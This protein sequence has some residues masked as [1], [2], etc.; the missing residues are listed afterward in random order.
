MN[1]IRGF[2]LLFLLAGVSLCEAQVESG[3]P[4]ISEFLPNPTGELETEWIELYNP[5]PD[6][7]LLHAFQIG[8][9]W[10]AYGI[11]DTGLYLPP[12]EY[13]ILAWEVDRFLEYYSGF[14]GRIISPAGGWPALNNDGDIV[15]LLMW[16]DYVVDS[17]A[18]EAVFGDNRSW[19]R[20][21]DADDQTIWGGSFSPSGSSPGEPNSF[22]SPRTNSIDLD[23]S[24]DPF[25]P[26]GDGFEDFTVISINP[27]EA[28]SLELTVYDISGRKRKTLLEGSASIPSEII[29]DGR[30]DNGEYLPVGIYVVYASIEGGQS[31][32]LKK[33]VVIAR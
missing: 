25:S 26:G 28:G 6:T 3:I 9:S 16:G 29:W 22:F 24:P 8:D 2:F 31:M 23:I 21:I 7:V 12:Q 4:F 32:S 10:R 13:I 1:K 33:T 18:Y 11:S 15:R 19:E 17:A 14:E 30:D 20:F 5:N 27:P